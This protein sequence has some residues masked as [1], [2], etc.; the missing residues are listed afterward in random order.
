L[1]KYNFTAKD[2][3]GTRQK[4]TIEAGNINLFYNILRQ[5]GLYCITVAEERAGSKYLNISAKKLKTKQPVI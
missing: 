1:P 2:A 4:G 5:R 3:K